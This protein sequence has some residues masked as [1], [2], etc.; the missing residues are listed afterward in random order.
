MYEYLICRCE[1]NTLVQIHN[2]AMKIFVLIQKI[3]DQEHD[4][5]NKILKKIYIFLKIKT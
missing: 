2:K 1:V 3:D 5:F 4:D